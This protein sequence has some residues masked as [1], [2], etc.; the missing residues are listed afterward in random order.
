MADN[1]TR[2]KNKPR[3]LAIDDAAIML[4]RLTLLLN[5]HYS[6]VTVNS[7]H[8]ALKYLE[9]EKPDLILLDIKMLPKD[10]FETLRDIRKMEG[11]EEIPVIMLTGLEDKQSV[12]ESVNLGVCDYILKP[13]E[14][15]VL[16]ERIEKALAE[17]KSK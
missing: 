5:D 12:I 15:D 3:I 8:R 9:I 13:F 7:G 10:G 14:S 16:I 6:I 1:K 11:C 4:R 17:S 2:G